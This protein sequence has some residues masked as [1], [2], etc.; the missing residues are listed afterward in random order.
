MLLTVLISCSSQSDSVNAI[1]NLEHELYSTNTFDHK[2]AEQ[3][4]DL[5]EQYTENYPKDS[6]AAKY[7]FM[8]AEVSM[9]M[10]S[11]QK[12]IELYERVYSEYP[13][14]PKSATSLFLIGFVNETQNKNL[15]EAQ[16]Y[17]LKFIKEFPTHN[18]IDDAK[19]SLANLGKSD[20][21]IIREFEAKLAKAK[22]DTL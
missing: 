6:L 10:G 1:E 21:E 8:G 5:Y 22:E 3:L 19:F 2:T 4:V 11:A 20:E 15:A 7:L 14:F 16:K 13:D 18:L 12:A 17:Y 9:G